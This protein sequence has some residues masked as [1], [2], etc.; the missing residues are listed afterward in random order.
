MLAFHG[1]VSRSH[2]GSY[3]PAIVVTDV[4]TGKRS[5]IKLAAHFA[6]ME[7]ARDQARER[8]AVAR[9]YCRMSMPGSAY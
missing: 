8:A 6:E 3:V 9:A 7:K 4:T 1:S 2:D 5:R